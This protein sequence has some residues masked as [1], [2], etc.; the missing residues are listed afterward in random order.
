MNDTR[1]PKRRSERFMM[2]ELVL[3][4]LLFALAIFLYWIPAAREPF[5]PRWWSLPVLAG[6]FFGLLWLHRWRRQN[7]TM[8]ARQEAVQEVTREAREKQLEQDR[9]SPVAVEPSAAPATSTAG[10]GTEREGDRS[11]IP[12]TGEADA[13]REN[14]RVA[15]RERRP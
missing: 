10:G 4:V 1:E 7:R 5:I 11:I 13:R 2:L 6:L 9:G 3:G 14:E 15:P 12:A 8:E